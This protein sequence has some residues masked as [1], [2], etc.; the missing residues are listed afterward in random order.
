ME[1]IVY[2]YQHK[3]T[4]IKLDID[5]L[6]AKYEV[7]ENSYV[8]KKKWALP[9]VFI[10][11]APFFMRHIWHVKAIIVS[12]GAFWSLVPAIFGRLFGKPVYIILHGT[13]CCSFPEINYGSLRFPFLRMAIKHSCSLAHE[14]LPVSQSLVYTEN[15][16]FNQAKTIFQGYEHFFGK[17][18]TP[19]TV[20]H[21]GIDVEKWPVL[22]HVNRK[23]NRFVTVMSGKHFSSFGRSVQFCLVSVDVVVYL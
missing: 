11:Q 8:W 21:N 15:N 16:Y 3:R 9:F 22:D 18:K 2:V 6:S 17:L 5:L 4:F 19:H 1:K 12:F 13:D 14:L 7:I 20:I 10:R 23:T